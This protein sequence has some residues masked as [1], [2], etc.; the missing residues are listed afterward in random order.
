LAGGI[1]NFRNWRRQFSTT[2][3]IQN[4]PMAQNIVTAKIQEIN[5]KKQID[6][7]VEYI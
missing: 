3:D 1:C 6:E 5:Q 7:L 2:C 4:F